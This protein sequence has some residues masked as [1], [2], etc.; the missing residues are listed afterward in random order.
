VPTGPGAAKE[1][2]AGISFRVPV[3][4]LKTATLAD[5]RSDSLKLQ[6]SPK[7]PDASPL[8]CPLQQLPGEDVPGEVLS[9]LAARQGQGLPAPWDRAPEGEGAPQK[10][11]N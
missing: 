8:H 2:S 5:L 10:Y 4:G 9:K 6:Y 7:R 1:T 11:A 3:G